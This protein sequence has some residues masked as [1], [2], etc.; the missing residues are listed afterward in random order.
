MNNYHFTL[1]FI[2]ARTGADNSKWISGIIS[3]SFNS[4]SKALFDYFL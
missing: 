2:M 1:G 4:F 3:K